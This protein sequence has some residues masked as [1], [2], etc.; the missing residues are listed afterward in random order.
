MWEF[1]KTSTDNNNWTPGSRGA[2]YIHARTN[3]PD[4]FSLLDY[5]I[6]TWNVGPNETDDIDREL[7]RRLPI[8]VVVFKFHISPSGGIYAGDEG[9]QN[10]TSRPD[11]AVISLL[12]RKDN[13]LHDGRD[14]IRFASTEDNGGLHFNLDTG[15]PCYCGFG[16][17]NSLGTKEANLKYK[18]IMRGD[19]PKGLDPGDAAS[20]QEYLTRLVEGG[21]EKNSE[22]ARL[23]QEPIPGIKKLIPWLVTQMQKGNIVYTSSKSG[24]PHSFGKLQFAPEAVG[25][26]RNTALPNARL[27]EFADFFNADNSP[28]RLEIKECP[29]CKGTGI[30]EDP[31]ERYPQRCDRCEGKRAI[32]TGNRKVDLNRLEIPE[33]TERVYDHKDW[34]KKREEEAKSKEMEAGQEKVYEFPNGWYVSKLNPSAEEARWEGIIQGNCFQ[35]PDMGY[36]D[37]VEKGLYDIYVLKS[38]DGKHHALWGVNPDD[39]TIGVMEDSSKMYSQTEGWRGYEINNPEIR[40]MVSEAN[41][42]L[43]INDTYEGYEENREYFRGR[44]PIQLNEVYSLRDLERQYGDDGDGGWEDAEYIAQRDNRTINEDTEII[45]GPIMWD[46]IMQDF[47]ENDHAINYFND[48]NE[49]EWI[50]DNVNQKPEMAEAGDQFIEKYDLWEEN[51]SEPPDNEEFVTQYREWRRLHGDPMTGEYKKPRTFTEDG[52]ATLLENSQENP[53]AK[54]LPKWED[55]NRGILP[56]NLDPKLMQQNPA[57]DTVTCN[58]CNGR[59]LNPDFKGGLCRVCDGVGT[60]ERK[61]ALPDT[62]DPRV[63]NKEIDRRQ[64]VYEEPSGQMF[65]AKTAKDTLKQFLSSI[66][67]RHSHSL[68]WIK[69]GKGR[70]LFL[71]DGKLITWPVNKKGEPQHADMYEYLTNTKLPESHSVQDF[72]EGTPFDIYEDGQLTFFDE[73]LPLELIA[74]LSKIDYRLKTSNVK[75]TKEFTKE[76]ALDLMDK[77]NFDFNTDEFIMGMNDELEHEDVTHGDPDMTAKIVADHLREHPDYYTQLR[78][79][80]SSKTYVGFDHHF[81]HLTGEPC[82]CAYGKSYKQKYRTASQSVRKIKNQDQKH[83]RSDEGQEVLNFLHKLISGHFLEEQGEFGQGRQPGAEGLVPWIIKMLKSQYIIPIHANEYNEITGGYGSHSNPITGEINNY[84]RPLED[85]EPSSQIID[86]GYFFEEGNPQDVKTDLAK[87]AKAPPVYLSTNNISTVDIVNR[88]FDSVNLRTTFDPSEAGAAIIVFSD[89]D[90]YQKTGDLQKKLDEFISQSPLG[91]KAAIAIVYPL[92]Y[93]WATELRDEFLKEIETVKA[94]YNI[95]GTSMSFG[96]L[97]DEADDIAKFLK[98]SVSVDYKDIEEQKV[99]LRSYRTIPWSQ[100]SRWFNASDAPARQG[101]NIME[102]V[103]SQVDSAA[104]EHTV[105][106]EDLRRIEDNRAFFE[107]VKDETTVYKIQDPEFKGW[108]INKI[109]NSDD[110]IHEGEVLK[111]CIGSSEQNYAHNIDSGNIAA[112]SLRDSEGLPHAAFHFNPDG[113]LAHIQGKAGYLDHNDTERKYRELITEFNTATDHDDSEGEQGSEHELRGNGLDSLQLP[114]PNTVEEFLG[115]AHDY[116]EV[117]Y[118]LA[119]DMGE[120]IDENTEVYCGS[121]DWG[122]IVYDA[123]NH[124]DDESNHN[125]DE[126]RYFFTTVHDA[127]EPSDLLDGLKAALDGEPIDDMFFDPN[128]AK[129]MFKKW[130][131]AYGVDLNDEGS[132]FPKTTGYGA[133]SYRFDQEQYEALKAK[134]PELE[135]PEWSTLP[136]V[137]GLDEDH[138]KR[139]FN[140]EGEFTGSQHLKGCL[141]PGIDPRNAK[142]E[143]LIPNPAPEDEPASMPNLPIQDLEDPNNS[144]QASAEGHPNNL[145]FNPQTGKPCYCQ[146]GAPKHKNTMER[147]ASDAVRKIK[148][149]GQKIFRTEEGMETLDA[150][151]ALISGRTLEHEQKGDVGDYPGLEGMVPWIVNQIKDRKIRYFPYEPGTPGAEGFKRFTRPTMQPTIDHFAMRQAGRIGV[152]GDDTIA[153]ARGLTGDLQRQGYRADDVKFI[154]SEPEDEGQRE[155]SGSD[156]FDMLVIRTPK[157][158]SSGDYCWS[159]DFFINYL[160]KLDPSIPKIILDFPNFRL[161][162]SDRAINC[163]SKPML[164][165]YTEKVSK[166]FY[167][168]QGLDPNQMYSEQRIWADGQIKERVEEA[169]R[170]VVEEMMDTVRS[171]SLSVAAGFPMRYYQNIDPYFEENLTPIKDKD[172]KL[173]ASCYGPINWDPISEWFNARQAPTRKS[174]GASEIRGAISRAISTLNYRQKRYEDTGEG[175]PV[176]TDINWRNDAFK[177]LVNEQLNLENSDPRRQVFSEA[178]ALASGRDGIERTEE[179][180]DE[181]Y[182]RAILDETVELA[183]PAFK[184]DIMNMD[185]SKVATYAEAHRQYLQELEQRHRLQEYYEEEEPANV[186]YRI[187]DPNYE[188]WTVVK[189]EDQDGEQLAKESE[190]LGHCIGQDEMWY[191]EAIL[192]GNIDAYSLRDEDNIPKLT[193]HFNND[194]T[195]ARVQGKS[196]D[197]YRQWRSLV[198]EFNNAKHLDDDGGGSGTEHDGGEQEIEYIYNWELDPATTMGQYIECYD[199]PWSVAKEEIDNLDDGQELADDAEVVSGGANYAE[200]VRDFFRLSSGRPMG[201]EERGDARFFEILHE[202][203]D[204]EYFMEEADDYLDRQGVKNPE[205]EINSNPMV[206]FYVAFRDMH[207][208]PTD[209]KFEE[210]K[211]FTQDQYEEFME[212]HKDNPWADYLP[213]FEDLFTD[214]EPAAGQVGA[215]GGDYGYLPASLDPDLRQRSRVM[216]EVNYTDPRRICPECVG[217]GRNPFDGRICTRCGGGGDRPVYD[218]VTFGSGKQQA[219]EIEHDEGPEMIGQTYMAK[220]TTEEKA[221]AWDKPF[222]KLSSAQKAYLKGARV[223]DPDSVWSI[224]D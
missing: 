62:S 32:P 215:Y 44:K 11:K 210:P 196:D 188:G 99:P 15:E 36:Q 204:L 123:L 183:V 130:A 212:E 157:D 97:Y 87:L 101:K 119:N 214:F 154:G 190:S 110:A 156:N 203:S 58:S 42:A 140:E 82:N 12:H 174:R 5:S 127:Y 125:R 105:Y 172:V 164:N 197:S 208:D 68:T 216:E 13:R 77:H 217:T 186:V 153:T 120:E 21:T 54:Q 56:A 145:H 155:E 39:S 209:N 76:D 132:A 102:M 166:E 124:Y 65:F 218:P 7:R 88:R 61:I 29:K 115:Q 211:G 20:F 220:L 63:Q 48:F 129:D 37:A 84:S 14:D 175:G 18:D 202:S 224:I 23:T 1:L 79:K 53:W 3:T 170:P 222:D 22:G 213:K 98:E 131:A 159:L 111:H 198:S 139:H 9:F 19:I 104:K 200:L 121:P 95:I 171:R 138:I 25:I 168:E 109:R 148:N 128:M 147:T 24:D 134:H 221:A 176:D 34:V 67:P 55:S 86:L 152:I 50:A 85:E 17:A 2:G 137:T 81:H 135:W 151:N 136:D 71:N 89:P 149:Q 28:Y 59:R 141:L 178:L 193:W 143:L 100:W 116:M 31:N 113:T 179:M 118:D 146:Y 10:R 35:N 114:D 47:F 83:L 223:I 41:G 73:A 165:E 33:I 161:G 51:Q 26:S 60:L 94:K 52:W 92:Y 160:D 16:Q 163:V 103:P 142:P 27:K 184:V 181:D 173:P 106:L 4:S 182:T 43:D 107:G 207:T 191:R 133:G 169:L 144:H 74:D 162:S 189:L 80:I 6:R 180:S 205:S 75:L 150:L 8:D 96:G 49:L 93:D 69:G 177:S 192:N 167:Q 46:S 38:P 30:Y 108:T 90:D 201:F 158:V 78:T 64:K 66:F 199:D 206:Q 40:A 57:T 45:R 70:G 72:V 91:S 122:D 117:A 185:I 126:L 112:F 219:Y 187:Q 194:S 195:L